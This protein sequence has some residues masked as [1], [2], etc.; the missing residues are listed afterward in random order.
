M[1]NVQGEERQRRREW[2]SELKENGKGGWKGSLKKK[3]RMEGREG[4]DGRE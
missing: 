4:K 3:E 1:R 2:N